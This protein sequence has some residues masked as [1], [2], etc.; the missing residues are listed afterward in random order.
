[1]KFKHWGRHTNEAGILNPW[2]EPPWTM[3]ISNPGKLLKTDEDDSSQGFEQSTALMVTRLHDGDHPALSPDASDCRR[4]EKQ[5]RTRKRKTLKATGPCLK[6]NREWWRDSGQTRFQYP[7]SWWNVCQPACRI[8]PRAGLAPGTWVSPA[9]RLTPQA[10]R[11]K[12]KPPWLKTTQHNNTTFYRSWGQRRRRCQ[13]LEPKCQHSNKMI[14]SSVCLALTLL[15][16]WIYSDTFRKH[17]L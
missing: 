7:G 1:M 15:K 4:L 5:G 2:T 9:L 11:G 13:T 14:T 17:W 10:Q 3:R 12:V 8:K 16:R 6:H